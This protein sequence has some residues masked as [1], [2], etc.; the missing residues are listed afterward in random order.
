[1]LSI[2]DITGRIVQTFECKISESNYSQLLEDFP[3]LVSGVYFLQ[4]Q[5]G[6]RKQTTKFIASN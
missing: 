3:N 1:M 6:D 2:L 4:V 5:I